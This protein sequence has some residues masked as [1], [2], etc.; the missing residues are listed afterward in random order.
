MI[1]AN[2]MV[3]DADFHLT[4]CDVEIKNG[5]I[6]KIQN[7]IEGTDKLDVTGKYILPGFIDSHIHGANGVR[8][9]D[10]NPD[11]SL[12]TRYE[13]TQGVTSIAITTFSPTFDALLNRFEIAAKFSKKKAGSKIAGIHAEGPF[14]SA[15]ANGITELPTIEKLDA[16]VEHSHGLLKIMTISPEIDGA[17]EIIRYAVSKGITV[18]LGHSNADYETTVK[19]I[20]AGAT[21]STHTFN[22]AR[23]FHHREPGIVGAVLTDPNVYCE[24]ICDYVHLHPATVKLIYMIKG[25]ERTIMVSDSI[26]ATGTDMKEY[27]VNGA[28]RYVVDGASRGADGTILGSVRS[29]YYD[30]KNLYASEIPLEHISKMASLNPA[31]SMKIDHITGSI[32]EGKAADIVILNQDYDLEATYLDGECVFHK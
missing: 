21:Q 7:N 5:R 20:A 32:A 31:K 6:A 30:V 22:A 8:I 18:A 16:M 26:T 1:F 12:I 15:R 25:S 28:T 24:M 19:A 4:K 10:V 11:L 3:M 23:S 27:V 29:L 13:A 9:D 14:L 2:G 17:E